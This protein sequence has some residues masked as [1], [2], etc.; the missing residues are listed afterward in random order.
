MAPIVLSPVNEKKLDALVARLHD[1]SIDWHRVNQQCEV[2]V[3]DI[4]FHQIKLSAVRL[5]T[6]RIREW[7]APDGLTADHNTKFQDLVC[8]LINENNELATITEK[9]IDAVTHRHLE[10]WDRVQR[11]ELHLNASRERTSECEELKDALGRL[12][13]HEPPYT[14]CP[15]LK[16]IQDMQAQLNFTEKEL[17]ISHPYITI[18][19]ILF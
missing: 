3:N 15:M 11:A 8:T 16:M 13:L 7:K 1:L 6:E 4:S 9:N 19:H 5:E 12:L 14:S 18:M 10:A 2:Y 17:Q